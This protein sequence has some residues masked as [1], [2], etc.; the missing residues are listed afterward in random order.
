MKLSIKTWSK[1][2]KVFAASVTTV[3]VAAAAVLSLGIVSTQA[4]SCPVNDIMPCGATTPSGFISKLTANKPSDMKTIYAD[5]RYNL[6]ESQYDEFVKYAVAGKINPDNGNITVGDVTVGY[7]GQSI[8]RNA[9]SGSH[10]ISIGGILY[11][12]SAI[13]D[14]TQYFNDSMVLFDEKG[15]IQTVIM[16]LCGNPIK[17]TPNNPKYECKALNATKVND[18]TY[19]FSSSVNASNGAVVARVVYDFGDGT[20]QTETS[21]STVVTHSYAKPGTYTAKVT[22]Y[23][24]TTFGRGEFPITVTAD[25]KKT[26]TIKEADKPAIDITKTVDGVKQKEVALNTPF[27]YQLIVKNTGNIDLKDA[28]VTDPSPHANIQFVATDKGAITNNAL[29]HTIPTFKVGETV[30]INIT[31]KLTAYVAGN[32]VNKACVDTPTI[33]GSPDD[34]DTATITTPKP[35]VPSVKIDKLVNGKDRD[36]VEVGEVFTYTVKVTNDGEVTLVKALVTDPAPAGVTMLTT[37]KGAIT[38]NSL[39]Y[40]IPTLNVGESTT[41]TITAKVAAYKSGDIVN[42]ACVN[43]VEVNPGNPTVKDDCDDAT[44]TVNKPKVPGVDIDKL[45]NGK[46]SAEVAVGEVFTYTIKVTNNGEVK[47]VNPVVSDPA[48]ANIQFLTTDRGTITN[49]VLT[50]TITPGLEVQESVTITMTAK[51]TA[52]VDGNIK[53]TACVDAVE[54]PG[55]KDACDDAYVSV[56]PVV[57]KNPGISIVK[58]VNG[59][60]SAQVAVGE[61]FTY[62]LVVK[63]TGD[64]DLTAV[65]VTDVAPEGVTLLSAAQGSIV[66]NT[67]THVIPSLK[68]GE[69]QEFTM[70]AKVV[71]YRAGVT[72]NTACVNAPAVN[73]E[74]PDKDDACDT[75]SV[76]VPPVTLPEVLP[77]TGAGSIISVVV[78]TVLAAGLLHSI[79]VRRKAAQ[80]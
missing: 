64:I 45:V 69:S 15:N 13:K 65:K 40:E 74:T 46:D 48:P 4:T 75:A 42:T 17:V 62:K 78:G 70:T 67:W 44:V 19:K 53:N 33:P 72:V 22:A 54:V 63:N 76:T 66:G 6:P 29:S 68:V 73:P 79:V 20:T 18:T 28:V 3:I 60:D 32:I 25:C 10:T 43:A 47:L 14:L 5:P 35:K 26:I 36:A 50:Y 39:S 30:T 34:C 56:P 77:D 71:A 51:V 23:V 49:N 52:Q 61:V 37:D 38:N 16:N 59:K 58:T 27:V 9:K 57:I 7:D 21:P 55:D 8:G 2:R 12:E 1:A 41:I 31:A 80:L 24:K 11:H